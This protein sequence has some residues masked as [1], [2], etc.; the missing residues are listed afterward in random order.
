VN[1]AQPRQDL[2]N[3][4]VENPNAGVE[5]KNPRLV[6]QKVRMV[7]EKVRTDFQKTGVF[8]PFSRLARKWGG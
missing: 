6:F 3:T 1:R 5:N 2:K 7:F 4:G 8:A